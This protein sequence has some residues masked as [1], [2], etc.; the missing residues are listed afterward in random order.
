M[1]P[2]EPCRPNNPPIYIPALQHAQP[3]LLTAR[4]L[5]L[6][7]PTTTEPPPPPAT[8]AD[9][10]S[11]PLH[12]I[13]AVTNRTGRPHTIPHPMLPPPY[14]PTTD[15]SRAT[16][17][18]PKTY[19]YADQRAL[20]PLGGGSRGGG[21]VG[22]CAAAGR[23][24]VDHEKEEQKKERTCVVARARMHGAVRG[25]RRTGRGAPTPRHHPPRSCPPAH[26]PAAPPPCA[27]DVQRPHTCLPAAP[28]H[29]L[30][31][32]S[33]SV[34]APHPTPPPPPPSRPSAP[35][36]VRPFHFLFVPQRQP[37]C[38]WPPVSAVLLCCC[39]RHCRTAC[40][41]LLSGAAATTV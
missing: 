22:G 19:Q 31:P 3:L 2:N 41:T 33:S 14:A 23:A 37:V 10:R 15:A 4:R 9:T 8:S 36:P 27:P 7:A 25:A 35:P 38:Q 21:I 16:V 29:H 11:H 24:S 39:G 6:A 28:H 30:P 34:P 18:P 12:L 40:V 20:A 13:T 26:V 5:L 17:P 1:P 32:P